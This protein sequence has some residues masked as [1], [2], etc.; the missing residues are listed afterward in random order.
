MC[1]ILAV[2]GLTGDVRANRKQILK[3]SKRLRH[4]GPDWSSIKVRDSCFLCHE[5]MAVTGTDKGEGRDDDAAT[6]NQPMFT[7]DQKIGWVCN[8]EIYNHEKLT[9]QFFLNV[10]SQSD[11]EVV[12][13]LYQ[14]FG[15]TIAPMLDGMWVF[16]LINYETGEIFA[17]RD[18]M[19]ICP[20]YYGYDASGAVYFASEMKALVGQCV[21]YYAFPPGHTY[22]AKL[23]DAKNTA[24]LERWYTPNWL[25]SSV[26][27]RDP[28]DFDKI[29]YALTGAVKKRL[30][31]DVPFGVLLSGGLD[32]SLVTSIAT[33]VCGQRVK[34]FSIGLK[35]SP[36]L[37]N[38]RKVASFLG[39]DHHEFHFTVEDA[40]DALPDLIYHLESWHQVRASMPMYMLARKIKSLGVKMVLSGE[41]ADEVYGG[42]LYFH[43]APSDRHFQEE[44][45]R[46]TTRLHEWD[47]LRANKSTMA[48]GLEARVP[49]LDKEF[50]QLSMNIDP[51][52]KMIDLSQ[53]PDGVHAKAE[54]YILRKAFDTPDDPYLPD[55]VLWRQKEAFSDGVGYDWVDGLKEYADIEVSDEEFAARHERWSK[56]TPETKE[57]YLLRHYFEQHYPDPCAAATVPDGKSIACSTP[58][59]VSWYPEWENQASDISG[60]AVMD[61]H[62]AGDSNLYSAKK[63]AEPTKAAM[64]AASASRTASYSTVSVSANGF[65]HSET[66]AQATGA[67]HYTGRIRSFSISPSVVGRSLKQ[68]RH[69]SRQR[70]AHVAIRPVAGGS[71]VRLC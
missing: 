68:S 65:K 51:R 42:Y 7:K 16:A 66:K 3:L 18:H 39:T 67:F 4:R 10:R 6:G 22:V 59:A 62:Q 5:R 50:L 45:V 57:Y 12:G 17:G 60:R 27:P 11:S 64:T 21:E 48:W 58:E 44:L 40:L 37:V 13:L 56:D 41:G 71:M 55:E 2:F 15:A 69:V 24:K 52:E 38:A 70:A 35:G 14:K 9:E 43:K 33:R 26:I 61:V 63:G 30:M 34:S 29:R 32:S 25:D 23:G 46:K 53:K 28:V 49:F 8:G 1:G 36:D 47:V 20:M 54:K 19:G 31:A